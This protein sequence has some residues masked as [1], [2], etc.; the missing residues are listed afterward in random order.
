MN[1]GDVLTTN[2]IAGS[3]ST[4]SHIIG[5]LKRT[6]NNTNSKLFPVGD[7]T[8]FRPVSVVPQNSTSSDYTVIFNGS[9][10]SSVNFSQY[11]NGTPSG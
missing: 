8:K 11:P 3:F 2:S 10:H 4:A 7:G 6:T 5:L 9:S 1:T